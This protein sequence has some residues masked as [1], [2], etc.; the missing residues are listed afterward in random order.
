MPR[1]LELLD[2]E[3]HRVLRVAREREAAPHF[4]QV[5]GSEFAA[6]ATCCPVLLTKTP[7]TGAFYA[8]A[9]YGFKPG[10]NLLQDAAGGAP[11]YHPLD[12]ERQGFFISAE[13]IA[14]D[15][16][17]PRFDAPDGE[18]LFDESGAPS[19]RLRRIQQVLARLKTGVEETDKFIRTMLAHRLVDPVDV[20]LRFDDGETLTLQGLYTISLDS[21]HELDDAAVLE[22]FRHGYLQLTYCMADSLKQ[23]PA[24]AHRR[25][26]RLAAGLV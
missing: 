9:M 23:I 18:T 13:S 26:R 14:I 22:L 2:S 11:P 24:L 19:Q 5:V 4:V 20:T 10:E 15:P 3:V 1:E 12:L 17:H 25:N 16:D 6:A 7:E 21:L 8:G